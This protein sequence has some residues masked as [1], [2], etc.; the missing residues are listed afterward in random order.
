MGRIVGREVGENR[1][2]RTALG[3]P[4][5]PGLSCLRRHGFGDGVREEDRWCAAT[6]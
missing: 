4:L 2:R 5:R 3:V 1:L 6:K